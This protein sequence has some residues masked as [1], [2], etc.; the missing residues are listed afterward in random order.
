[1]DLTVSGALAATAGP[2]TANRPDSDAR[3][4]TVA[5]DLEATFLSEMLK[6]AGFGEARDSFGGGTGEA[7]FASLL[8][9]EQAKAIAARGGLGLA[10]SIFDALKERADAR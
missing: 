7:Q 6:H 8:R 9:D 10:E 2:Q 4:L 5:R 3:L 1:M